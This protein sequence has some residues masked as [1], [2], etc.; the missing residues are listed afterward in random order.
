MTILIKIGTYSVIITG[1]LIIF[2]IAVQSCRDYI[3]VDPST[4]GS[5]KSLI[6]QTD[7]VSIRA[8]SPGTFFNQDYYENNSNVNDTIRIDFSGETNIDSSNSCSMTI[9][10][11]NLDNNQVV[12][13][14][15]YTRPDSINRGY[16]VG[17]N[18]SGIYNYILYFNVTII[19]SNGQNGNFYLKMKGIKVWNVF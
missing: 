14:F 16:T 15:S 3:N 17:I 19:I 6:F 5:N 7:S 13:T 18:L 12:K 11:V 2:A 10:L 8:T 9:T 4:I 1:I